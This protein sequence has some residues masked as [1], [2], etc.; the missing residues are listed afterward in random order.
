[1]TETET[2]M[3]AAHMGHSY[4]IHIKHYALQTE[5]FEKT[6]VAKVLT[7]VHN[8]SIGKQME[9]TDV[10]QLV[11]CDVTLADDAVVGKYDHFV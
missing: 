4:N 8:G 10:N 2:R 5:L 7:A 1:M 3:L 9:P 11:P 6:K